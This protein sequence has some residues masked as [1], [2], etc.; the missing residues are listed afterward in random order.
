M[1]AAA[2]VLLHALAGDRAAD[3]LGEHAVMASDIADAIGQVLKDLPS[4]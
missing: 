2:G 1:F 3:Q 4:K